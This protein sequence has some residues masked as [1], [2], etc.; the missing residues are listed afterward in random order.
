MMI[1]LVTTTNGTC[2]ETT[3]RMRRREML[4]LQLE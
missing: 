2:A 3:C 1:G 4:P